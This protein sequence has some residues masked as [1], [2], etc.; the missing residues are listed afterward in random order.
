[1]PSKQL[2]KSDTKNW[3]AFHL[4][5]EAL[6][7][8]DVFV[9]SRVKDRSKLE[10]AKE[11]LKGAVTQDPEF[12]RARY[13][14]AVV[15]D[16]LGNPSEAVDELKAVVAKNPTFRSEAEYNLGVSYYH[17]Y[18]SPNIQSAL[19]TFEK[20]IGDTSDS[21]L[22]YMARAGLVRSFA[23]MVHHSRVANDEVRAAN[24]LTNVTDESEKL[25]RDVASDGSLDHTT[26]EE[27]K[28]RLLNG[29][30][31]AM[32][33]GSDLEKEPDKKIKNLRAALRDFHDA[34]KRSPGNWEIIC[35]FASAHMR[36][37]DA[38]RIEGRAEEMQKELE[39]AKHY[40]ND[41]LDR[42]RPD[43]GFARYEM[44]RVERLAGHFDEAL[45]W[46]NKALKIPVKER[47]V[48]DGT[49]A[50]EIERVKNGDVSL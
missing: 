30:G 36:L 4:A 29:R 17:L 31:V 19:T 1:M 2:E 16:M 10:E 35:N 42:V 23:M 3:G 8:I 33:F 21:V 20:V 38:R 47:N 24:F 7:D 15:D 50:K 25:L 11:K 6:R 49:I 32:M 40:L 37:G 9:S 27:I 14:S 28:W 44:G 26:Q 22:K 45:Q 34:N 39:T 41:V 48:G 5:T 46:F 13:Y 43:Y 18:S 12:N